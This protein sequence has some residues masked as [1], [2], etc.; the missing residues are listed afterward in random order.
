MTNQ[1]PSSTN[2]NAIQYSDNISDFEP[3]SDDEENDYL[4]A[5]N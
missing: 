1:Q 4:Y 2:A 5:L 3:S